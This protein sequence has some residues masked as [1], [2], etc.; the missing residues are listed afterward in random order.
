[1]NVIFE[2]LKWYLLAGLGPKLPLDAP[3]DVPLATFL[4]ARGHSLLLL[5]STLPGLRAGLPNGVGAFHRTALRPLLG[6]PASGAAGPRASARA[7]APAPA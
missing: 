7:G 6:H 1:M 2:R 4:F 5:R 3:V